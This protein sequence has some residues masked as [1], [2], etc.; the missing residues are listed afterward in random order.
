MRVNEGT[1][2]VAMRAFI[3]AGALKNLA[4]SPQVIAERAMPPAFAFMTV[5]WEKMSL[6]E[7]VW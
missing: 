2:V 3:P 7:W 6:I 1:M 4:T 5:G